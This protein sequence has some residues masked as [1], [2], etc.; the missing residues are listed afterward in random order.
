MVFECHQRFPNLDFRQRDA[1]D[2]SC[3]ADESFT[4][5]V[6]AFNGLDYLSSEGR[7]RC[8]AECHRVLAGD[9]IFIFSSHNP[10]SLLVRHDWNRE[11]V[12]T[13]SRA[14]GRGVPLRF[15]T[16]AVTLAAATRAA[17]RSSWGS[18]RRVRRLLTRTFW[19]G[20]GYVL[21]SAHGGLLTYCSTPRFVGDEVRSAGFQIL[22][23][24]GDEYP[25]KSGEF[26]TDW[27]YYACR[28]ANTTAFQRAEPIQAAA[29]GQ[30]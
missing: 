14:F 21:D 19:L 15:V 17:L 25:R 5:V 6:I 22:E 16:V 3:F 18:L 1:T 2:L 20:R 11:K 7:A 30:G 27:Y 24:L 13:M 9:G 10:R 26:M 8:L 12:L 29:G 28:K 23:S 4:A